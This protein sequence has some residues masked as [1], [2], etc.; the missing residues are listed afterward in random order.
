[1]FQ[2]FDTR[3]AG[4]ITMSQLHHQLSDFGHSEREIEACVYKLS[5]TS[6]INLQEFTSHYSEIHQLL[7]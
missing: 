2:R 7:D 3:N 5:G 1:M 4:S 6:T